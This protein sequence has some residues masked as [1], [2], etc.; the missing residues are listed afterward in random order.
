MGL[1]LSGLG[2]QLGSFGK[3]VCAEG[4]GLGSVSYTHLDV[5]KRQTGMSAWNPASTGWR[6]IRCP[7]A[8][9]AVD[10]RRSI[11]SSLEARPYRDV[12]VEARQHGLAVVHGSGYNPVSYTHLDVYKRQ[13]L[14][15]DEDVHVVRV[16]P[17]GGQQSVQLDLKGA[18]LE[19]QQIS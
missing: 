17:N 3:F 15:F 11:L 7:S 4:I 6:S 5:Y 2:A 14:H 13:H 10:W 1:V 19:Q 16:G 9:A 12:F 18:M 8:C